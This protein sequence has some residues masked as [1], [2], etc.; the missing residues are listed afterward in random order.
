MSLTLYYHPLSSYCHKVLIALYE[1]G[2]DFTPR[3]VDLANE[4]D[5]AELGARW[6]LCKIPV[7]HDAERGLDLP[8]S[9]IIIEHIDRCS[10]RDR[11]LI[12]AD[13]SAALKVRLWDRIFD[14]YVQSPMQEIVRNAIGKTGADERGP[15]ALLHAS[16]AMIDRQLGSGPWVASPDFSLAD[17]AAVPALFYA[18]TL[19]PIPDALGNLKAYFERLVERPSV[20]RTLDEARP[21]FSDYPFADAIPARFRSPARSS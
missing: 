13:A 2:T 9:S 7:V 21:Y 8:E 15:R 17:C 12:P 11:P 10:R 18:T 19:E 1:T 3:F 20:R 5:R 16:Y 4:A 6:P 14:D